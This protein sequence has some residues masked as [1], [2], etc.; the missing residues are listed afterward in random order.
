MVELRVLGSPAITT[1]S[2][3]PLGSVRAQPKRVAL[4]TYLALARS[5][6][7]HT[8]DHVLARLWPELD[9]S[10]ARAALRQAVHHLRHEL[11]EQAIITSGYD[12]LRFNPA[13]VDCD[14]ICFEA[15][16]DANRP[17]EALALYR[18]DLL[19]GFFVTAAPGFEQWLEEERARLRARAAAGAWTVAERRARCGDADDAARWG[20]RALGLSHD[21]ELVLQRLLRLLEQLGD[22]VRAVLEYHA[23]ARRMRR[24]YEME[25]SA[26]TRRIVDAIRAHISASHPQPTL[27]DTAQRV[28]ARDAKLPSTIAGAAVVASP[29]SGETPARPWRRK[30]E[31]AITLVSV[32]LLFFW[33]AWERRPAP[34]QPVSHG[35]TTEIGLPDSSPVAFLGAGHLGIGRLALALSPDGEDIVYTARTGSDTRLYLRQIEQPVPRPLPGTEG[36]SDP[37][38]SPDGRWV[39]FFAGNELRKV[40]IPEGHVVALA[41]VDEAT[42]GS[43]SP[44]GRILVANDEGTNIG[45]VAAEGGPFQPLAV[46]PEVR[47]TRFP[48][49]LP[50]DEWILHSSID[51]VLYLTSLVSGRSL[52]FKRTGALVRRDSATQEELLRGDSPRYLQGGYVTYL[53]GENGALMAL[54]FD[55]VT[56]KVLGSPEPVRDSIRKEADMGAGQ[57]VVS[58]ANGGM[59]LYAAGADAAVTRFGWVDHNGRR[60]T[61]PFAPARYGSFSLSPDGHRILSRVETPADNAE[62]WEL[63]LQ[64]GTHTVVTTRGAPLFMSTWWPDS[65]RILSG[66]LEWAW[67]RGGSGPILLGS[68]NGPTDTLIASALTALPSPDGKALLVFGVAGE[69]GLWLHPRAAPSLGVQLSKSFRSFAAF[70]PDGRWVAFMDHEPTQDIYVVDT[71]HPEQRYKISEG[72]GIEPRWP[73]RGH[74]I[75]Y[76]K[77]WSWWAVDV[78]LGDSASF[79]APRALFSGPYVNVPGWS[80]DVSADGKRHLVLLGSADESTDRLTI[81]TQWYGELRRLAPRRSR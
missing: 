31:A 46:Q 67:R 2:G 11:G 20:K 18:G 12:E 16:L 5:R 4:L 66:S 35:M 81:V 56:R 9:E 26:E 27:N 61:L 47:Y 77:G 42:G 79:S 68:E 41:Q 17:E 32:G 60:D 48:Q 74:T 39:A 64:T 71:Q 44:D 59:L 36:A 10:H 49:L 7:A 15:E 13:C 58:D 22:R 51:R 19:E 53:A 14:A 63:D 55:G 37:F 50:G 65:R 52:S 33:M 70:S 3:T 23:F 75:V 72:G 28:V 76:R 54:P 69:H 43:W 38:F 62:L 45:W 6:S 1:S 78:K 29:A 25:P 34:A 24:E 57:Y 40:S 21:D 30:R 8:R 73:A 80:H